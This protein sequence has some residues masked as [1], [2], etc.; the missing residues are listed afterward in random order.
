MR[1]VE[2]FEEL[3]LRKKRKLRSF[4][5]LKLFV[6]AN[7]Q[8]LG[9][10]FKSFTAKTRMESFIKFLSFLICAFN[11]TFQPKLKVKFRIFMVPCVCDTFMTLYV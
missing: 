4:S 2:V 10:Q 5:I 3:K 6:T 11:L 9:K 7:N 1:T 8:E